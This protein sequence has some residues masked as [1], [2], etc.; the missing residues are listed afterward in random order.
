MIIEHDMKFGPGFPG[1]DEN[2]NLAIG[3]C[4]GAHHGQRRKYT[5]EPYYTHC[6]EVARTLFRHSEPPA[7]V[8]AGLLHD[9]IEDTDRTYD[10]IQG[11]FGTHVADLVAE[12]TDVSKPED[13][14]RAARKAIDREHLATTSPEGA[15]IKLADTISNTVSII[16]YDKGFARVYIPEK[17]ELL[18]VLQH[19]SNKELLALAEA[20][21]QNAVAALSSC[22]S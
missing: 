12:V 21:V 2:L 17:L 9:V 19:A 11:I 14:N 10:D 6:L 15:N 3:F 4:M 8:I 22:R 13:G 20:T 1:A 18:K 7:V 16:E 5:G